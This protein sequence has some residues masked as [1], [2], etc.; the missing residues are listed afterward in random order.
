M[1]NGMTV[2][3]YNARE[4]RRSSCVAKLHGYIPFGEQTRKSP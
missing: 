4:R 3:E 1:I 2:E